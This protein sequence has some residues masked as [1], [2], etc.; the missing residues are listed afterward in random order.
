ME[1]PTPSSAVFYGALSVHLGAFLLLRMSPLLDESIV[2]SSLVVTLG[3]VTA[4]LAYV[5]GSVQTDIKSM[6]SY[7]SMLQVGLI[8][9]EIGAGLR[10]IPLAHILGH[11]SLRTLQFLRA[12]TLLH[13]YH[14]LENALGHHVP[15]GAIPWR[16]LLG[17]A[18][19]TWLYRLALERGY[20]DA[21]L[22]AYIVGPFVR[23]FSR[24]DAMERRLT[25]RLE[26]GESRES[27]RVH[28]HHGAIEELT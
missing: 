27:D 19:L 1:G 23:L 10:W 26:G 17:E 7:A 28:P 9:A 24:L 18:R 13:D 11:A 8:V 2:L 22:H 16:R 3:L 12:P 20:L 25:D 6:L 5:V 15:R 21:M 14:V 4:A